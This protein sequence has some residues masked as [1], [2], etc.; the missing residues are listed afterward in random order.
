M[1]KSL[2]QAVKVG[3]ILRPPRCALIRLQMFRADHRHRDLVD[4]IDDPCC[5]GL[6]EFQSG[7]GRHDLNPERWIPHTG[8]LI[9]LLEE[10]GSDTGLTEAEFFESCDDPSCVRLVCGDPDVHVGRR[11][12][13]SVVTDGVTADQ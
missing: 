5:I 4:K 11:A 6:G 8:D 9:A 10:A 3:E 13:M 12:W 2:R 1:W 7:D